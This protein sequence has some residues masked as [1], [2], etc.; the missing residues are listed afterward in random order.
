[1]GFREVWVVGQESPEFTLETDDFFRQMTTQTEYEHEYLALFSQSERGVFPEEQIRE[2][3]STYAVPAPLGKD[4]VC[5]VGVDCNEA[6]SGTHV[7]VMGCNNATQTVRILDVMIL[8]GEEFTHN[9]SIQMLLEIYLK[10]K[11]ERFALDKGFSHAQI[12]VLMEWALMNPE[13]GLS[14]ALV[15]YDLG[16]NYKF[17]NPISGE[18]ISRPYK[19][20][21]V[22]L[23]QR[24]VQHRKLVIPHS[25]D[26]EAG[27]VGQM[28]AFQVARIGQNNRPVYT[29]GNEHTLTAMMIGIMSWMLDIIGINPAVSGGRLATTVGHKVPREMELPSVS[30]SAG[31]GGD[32]SPIGRP[33]KL[34]GRTHWS[35][36]PDYT[37]T[38]GLNRGRRK[39]F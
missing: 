14:E 1:M 28:R 37:R 33:R 13:S 20:L 5:V 29:Q 23:S 12:E 2:C 25:Q 24:L 3:V 8:Q 6:S 7:V 15:S 19:P 27:L 26:K 18:K 21:M 17:T 11:P 16:S 32:P 34:P 31:V 4:E 30:R 9:R 39:M 35:Q 38:S 36:V 10:W 22:G